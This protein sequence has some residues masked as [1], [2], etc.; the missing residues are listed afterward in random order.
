MGQKYKVVNS[1]QSQVNITGELLITAEED[2]EIPIARED[3][4]GLVKP[5]NRTNETVPVT[6]DEQGRLYTREKESYTLPVATTASLGG[7]RPNTKTPDMT[8]VVGIDEDGKLYTSPASGLKGLDGFSPLVET[9]DN[10]QGSIIKITDINGTKVAHVHN[11]SKGD[12]GIPGERGAQGEQ[13][14]PGEKGPKGDPGERGPQG[15]QGI[16]GERGPKGDPGERGV[17]GAQG[18][19]GERGPKGD[20]GERGPQGEGGITTPAFVEPL[21]TNIFNNMIVGDVNKEIW[22]L[23]EYVMYTPDHIYIMIPVSK[24]GLTL[25]PPQTNIKIIGVSFITYRLHLFRYKTYIEQINPTGRGSFA[26]ARS[27]GD[28]ILIEIEKIFPR[29]DFYNALVKE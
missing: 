5:L 19:P 11:G 20:P 7:V 29:S 17:Q 6:V 10:E 26:T 1:K 2:K 27:Y 8:Q 4:L 18:K 14:M 24:F 25:I 28:A 23:V 22:D 16:P 12:K 3:Q 9:E 15:E 21:E 13:G